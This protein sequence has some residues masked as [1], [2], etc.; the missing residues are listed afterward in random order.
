M[1]EIIESSGV[2]VHERETTPT[3]RPPVVTLGARL[4]YGWFALWALLVTI[5]ASICQLLSHQ[6]HPT[7]RNFK[8]W[9]RLWGGAI[10]AGIG[11]RVR[12]EERIRLPRDRPYIFVS[13]HQSLLDILALSAALPYPFGFVAKEELKRVPFLGY[14]IRNS[15]CVF[16][17]RSDPRASIESLRKAGQRI[18]KGNSV[19]VFAEGTRSHGPDLQSFKKGA[20]ALAIEAGVPVVPVTVVDAYRLMDER[21]KAVRPGVLR[22]V[23]GEPLSMEGLR[24][25]DIPDAMGEVRARVDAALQRGT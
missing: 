11:V 13:N 23:L 8:F 17:D 14:A 3:A 25:K 5:P 12:V 2:H 24:R 20:F 4:L 15:A 19:L 6:F 10:L 18:R 22:I 16:I 7:A 21:R 9:S 1:A